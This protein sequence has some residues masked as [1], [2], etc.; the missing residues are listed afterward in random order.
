[1]ETTTTTTISTKLSNEQIEAI[2]NRKITEVVLKNGKKVRIFITTSGELC[3]YLKGSR[4]YGVLLD[5]ANIERLIEPKKID[6][7]LL[8]YKIISKFRKEAL[9]ATFNNS[10]IADCISLPD[11]FDKWVKDGKKSPYQYGIT[12]GCKITGQLVSVES[13]VKKLS[14][15]YKERIKEAIKNKT[16]FRTGRFDYNGYDG[17]IS[18]EI[19]ENGEWWGYFSKEYRNTCNGY[20]YLLIND[21]YFIGY[22]ID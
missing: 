14:L 18:F 12:T 11:N 2:K 21:E 13:I 8:N 7:D 6:N 10:F 15:Y 19:K 22:D 16:E 4:R 17:S 3:Q 5:E 9:K 20:Y 1:M